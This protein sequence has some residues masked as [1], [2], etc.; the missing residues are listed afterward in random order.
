MQHLD[1]IALRYFSETAH[2]GS[3]RL[4]ADRLH[5]TPSAVSRRIAKLE[6]QLETTLFERRPSGVALTPSG[7]ILAKEIGVIYSHLR[8]VQGMIG[9]L[10]GLRRGEVVVY[11][12][13]GAVD[14]WMS[15]VVAGYRAEYPQI[16][17]QLIVASADQ[18]SEA[19]IDEKCDIA[20]MFKAPSK[21][22]IEIIES[23]TEPVVALVSPAHALSGRKSISFEELLEHDLVLPDTSFGV[24]QLFDRQAR[25]IKTEAR[26]MVTTNSIAMTR[27]MVRT[28]NLA[29]V[30][31]YLSARH[32]CQLGLLQALPITRCPGF[33]AEVNLCVRKGRALPTAARAMQAAL[34]RSF[35]SWSQDSAHPLSA[36]QESRRVLT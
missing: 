28:A 7:E 35:A 15:S 18:A 36:K 12:M 19:L 2:S 30:L 21:T 13:E 1:L 4:A 24:R 9:D 27:S 6:H 14:W 22:E 16:S 3:I 11:C 5:V 25:K 34:Q 23:R 8:Q 29:T 20:V 31:P 33:H 32:D 10:E 26:C 17:F